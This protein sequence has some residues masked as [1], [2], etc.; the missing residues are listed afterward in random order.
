MP[1]ASL[2][3]PKRSRAR[4]KAARPSPPRT[5][6]KP[7]ARKVQPRPARAPGTDGTW[8]A[9]FVYADETGN[10]RV[11]LLTVTAESRES[12]QAIA[13]RHAPAAEFVVS[14][15]LRSDEQFLGQVRMQAL[16]AADGAKR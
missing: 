10:A 13:V 15:H 9:Q 7:R 8:V 12:A 3:R 5:T 11:A 6:A 14:L 1:E 2:A 16:N 4:R